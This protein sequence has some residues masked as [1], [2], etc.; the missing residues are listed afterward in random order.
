[1]QSSNSKR[2]QEEEEDE[3]FQKEKVLIANSKSGIE[4]NLENVNGFITGL[5][6][7]QTL[8]EDLNSS[9]SSIKKIDLYQPD[10]PF[11]FLTEEEK[12][13]LNR[14]FSTIATNVNNE[15]KDNYRT[16]SIISLKNQKL[17]S[18]KES[19]QVVPDNDII[20]VSNENEKR[21]GNDE[22]DDVILVTEL[23]QPGVL[24]PNNQIQEQNNFV[25]EKKKNYL[26]EIDNLINMDDFLSEISHELA[27]PIRGPRSSY[28]KKETEDI[29]SFFKYENYKLKEK[30]DVLMREKSKL[31]N[32][33]RNSL[34]EKNNSEKINIELKGIIELLQKEVETKVRLEQDFVD[35]TK[36]FETNENNYKDNF[37]EMTNLINTLHNKLKTYANDE[38]NYIILINELRK[39]IK[40]LSDNSKANVMNDENIFYF[41]G[42]EEN[43][44]KSILKVETACQV[45]ECN[46]KGNIVPGRNWHNSE[47]NC[48]N[49]IDKNINCL[50]ND[51]ESW[52]QEIEKLK[53]VIREQ[54]L[55][56]VEQNN[57][58]IKLK[59]VEVFKFDQIQKNNM[60]DKLKELEDENIRFYQEIKHGIGKI[61]GLEE[62]NKK[63]IVEKTELEKQKERLENR[64]SC[65]KSEVYDG[66]CSIKSFDEDS[67]KKCLKETMTEI[68]KNGNS[69]PK[70]SKTS[71]KK[72]NI[73]TMDECPYCDKSFT[74]VKVHIGHM[75]KC[76]IYQLK[77]SLKQKTM[78]ELNIDRFISVSSG[79]LKKMSLEEFSSLAVSDKRH[80]SRLISQ[81][82]FK[83]ILKSRVQTVFNWLERDTKGVKTL[84]VE[85]LRNENKFHKF[86][87]SII[88]TNEEWKK[89][90][91]KFI[92]AC[93]ER[94]RLLSEIE[95][96]FSIKMKEHDIYCELKCITNWFKKET[97]RKTNSPFWK[98]QFK[99]FEK[100]CKNKYIMVIE[101]DPISENKDVF[102]KV[103][104]DEKAIH[105]LLE[106][107]YFC[108]GET[109]K[110]MALE[111]LSYGISN[112][113]NKNVIEN[114]KNSNFK[115]FKKKFSEFHQEFLKGL[116]LFPDQRS[117]LKQ[118]SYEARH[119]SRIS[120]DIYYDAEAAKN[121][122]DILEFPEENRINGFIQE[123]SL[124]PFGILFFQIFSPK[125]P[126]WFFD[127]TGNVMKKVKGQKAAYL[128]SIVCHDKGN[129]NIVPVVEF[130]TTCHSTLSISKYLFSIKSLIS[131]HYKNYEDIPLPRVI[132]T[133]FSWPL[134][135]SV[136]ETFNRIS[137]STY[138]RLCF[139]KII[140][141][142]KFNE[143]FK[144]MII[145]YLCSTHFIKN[146]S[147]KAKKVKIDMQTRTAFIFS[148]TLIQNS[149][150]IEEKENYLL[151]IYNMFNRLIIGDLNPNLFDD[152]FNNT[153][154]RFS[155]NP[156]E[157]WFGHLK[158]DL[159]K[160]E[161]KMVSEYSSIVMNSIRSK[162]YLYYDNS[163]LKNHTKDYNKKYSKKNIKAKF[164]IWKKNQEIKRSREKGFFYKKLANFGNNNYTTNESKIIEYSLDSIFNLNYEK[165][166]VTFDRFFELIKMINFIY[167]SISTI[168]KPF[169]AYEKIFSDSRIDFIEII[170]LIRH[171]L[172]EYYFEPKSN[173]KVDESFGMLCNLNFLNLFYPI[174]TNG[175]GNCFYYSV[176]V[177]LF[178]HEQ[179]FKVIKTGSLFVL[180]EYRH[181]FEEI[182]QKK[183]YKYTFEELFKKTCQKNEWANELNIL[184]TSIFLKRPI[185]CYCLNVEKQIPYSLKYQP[186]KLNSN[187]I[188]IGFIKN[189]FVPLLKQ[190]QNGKNPEAKI[191]LYQEFFGNFFLN[192]FIP[193]SQCKTPKFIAHDGLKC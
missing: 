192:S 10:D 51:S 122:F 169:C 25:P 89:I 185:I 74:N 96:F 191:D 91:S 125:F 69:T 133:D 87:I 64:L 17:N 79:I 177:F 81:A 55:K 135:N 160:N 39:T 13:V 117:I 3:F 61:Q 147:K 103:Y 137:I 116:V 184:A 24:Y 27:A 62:E 53:A 18:P 11:G 183:C 41:N 120:T 174:K 77:T 50:T 92:N 105:G 9:I 153:L 90:L 157:N 163:D 151:I 144:N 32:D 102:I 57:Q 30:N 161:K 48:P 70:D 54:N 148:F 112:T 118:I 7:N 100:T 23:K 158:N 36:K 107:K 60:I 42:I 181:F 178:G 80:L 37:F 66:T 170:T 149:T 63:L 94:K 154:F 20:L 44:K 113:L 97:S 12:C 26:N 145:P 8:N 119:D 45:K 82:Y 75:H 152:G 132:V 5:K 106:K 121:I 129:R 19:K 190:D 127:A 141:R 167:D 175:D 76:K 15:I 155:N 56:I 115:N 40:N 168:S 124:N 101:K 172:D 52:N 46:G 171:K 186:E 165:D 156:V 71:P 179:N 109:R 1:M 58:I 130:I 6:F 111:V 126:I 98:G 136:L 140:D 187:P 128:Y 138:L 166:F 193:N 49:K 176:S 173:L 110:K 159:L 4:A 88:L 150:S 188:L 139:K 43:S 123:I 180:I 35:L 67:L 99:C 143:E 131:L 95:N 86:N 22:D 142:E 28:L 59:N 182:I 78:S 68:L 31:E 134:I 108:R 162:Y 33:L 72:K 164:E 73:K 85:R 38:Q 84:L 104:F 93:G 21:Q 14:S 189:H 114:K 34:A 2:Y 146:I 83:S 29:V 47:K 16:P 65:S